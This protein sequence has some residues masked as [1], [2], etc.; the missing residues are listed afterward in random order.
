MNKKGAAIILVLAAIMLLTVVCLDMFDDSLVSH[1]LAQ[2][3]RA[4]TQAYYL[5]KSGVNF[6]KM[7]LFYN[8]Q[9]ESELTKKKT[10]LQAL[11]YEPLY[12][13]I[14][15]SSEALR[16]MV[17]MG[18]MLSGGEEG[19]V[20]DGTE[21]EAEAEAE[22][23]ED[24]DESENEGDASTADSVG[25]LQKEGI[26]EFLGFE[27]NFDVEISEE[28]SKY[29]LNA[30]S[31]MTSNSPSYDLHKKVLLSLL[32][33]PEFKNFFNNQAQEAETL[34]HAIADFVDA[35]NVINEF[36]QVE[37]GDEGSAYNKLSYQA[38][39][40]PFLTL[41]ELR[42]VP[43]MGDDIFE[44]IKPLVSVYHTSEKVNVCLAEPEIVDALIAHY[45]KYS[46]CT[47]PL[48]GEKDADEIAKHRD[49]LLA[50]CPD[51]TAMATALNV[52]LGIS[53]AADANTATTTSSASGTT[54]NV[55]SATGKTSSKVAGCQIQFEDLIATDNNVFRIKAS[56]SVGDITSSIV[57]VL[58]TS[59]GK[60]NQWPVLYYRID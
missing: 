44:T 31:K 55:S 4:R 52:A 12:K 32:L 1:Q 50:L 14:P 24:K 33:R 48:D 6:S 51:K 47:T 19:E 27:G 36:D 57:I 11:G 2:N 56:G 9:V 59:G 21:D 25:M 13:M 8:K 42:L 38:K 39:D 18:A 54:T 3:Y 30:V 26:E 53:S 43:G 7:L 28:Q 37:R 16:G 17:S 46:E 41:S 23:E 34:T 40:G 58:D 60:A 22:A 5:A 45:T 20:T 10:S 15:L 35:N 49:E 29:S